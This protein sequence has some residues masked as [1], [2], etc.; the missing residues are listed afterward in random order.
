MNVEKKRVEKI[1]GYYGHDRSYVHMVKI[2]V[3]TMETK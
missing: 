1:K 3:M 2:I